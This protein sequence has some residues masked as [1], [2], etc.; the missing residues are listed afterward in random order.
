VAFVAFGIPETL[1]S[2]RRTSA[3]VS[4]V[5]STY[6]ALFR[7]R[8]FVA[9]AVVGA[10]AGAS[11]FAYNTG[12]PSALIEHYGM[13]PSAC[14]LSLSVIALSMALASQINAFLLKW[15]PPKRIMQTAV[16]AAAISTVLIL[17]AVFTGLGGANGLIA[18]LLLQI[19]TI[20]FILGNSMAG[21][22]YAAGMYA[23][24]ASAL[25]GVM[26]FVLGTVGSALIGMFHDS[27]GRLM[28]AVIAVFSLASLAIAYSMGPD[29]DD[30][31]AVRDNADATV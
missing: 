16:A 23:G 7:N 1:P 14:G 8:R 22:M 19:S 5:I 24:A 13:S 28:G 6:G 17:V 21:A 4:R 26:M 9:F 31:V 2:A 20:G 30:A 29:G 25:L 27:S 15:Y 12:A 3:G 18:M 10:C 11:Q